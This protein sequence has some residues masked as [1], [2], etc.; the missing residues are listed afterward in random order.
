MPAVTLPKTTCLPSK[1]GVL[2]VQRK[3]WLP[4]V[5]GPEFALRGSLCLCA[6]QPFLP[7]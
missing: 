1:C 4:L 6:C 5:F 2:P 3:N 7:M